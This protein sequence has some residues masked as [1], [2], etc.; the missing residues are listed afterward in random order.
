MAGDLIAHRLGSAY[1]P[2]NSETALRRSL[3]G[4]L[5]GLE[6][7]VCLTADGGLVLLHD[8]LLS[9]GTT[10][11]GW[12]HERTLR[13]IL[14]GS[15]LDSDGE[16]AGEPPLTLEHL[17]E[18]VPLD[19][20]VQVEVKTQSNPELARRTAGAICERYGPS[21]QRDRLEVISFHT[22]ACEVAA[23]AGLRTRLVIWAD[24]APETLADWALRHGVSGV[25]VEYFLLSDELL[26]PLRAAGITV[27]TGTVNDV[28][29][30]E[31]ILRIEPR[32]ITTDRPHELR[33]EALARG[34]LPIDYELPAAA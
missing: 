16:P 8:P 15:L 29:L 17:L 9:L 2:D 4:P 28:D 12:V 6:T 24:Y 21:T 5:K 19:L 27:S 14:G 1:G 34:L 22:D 20:T 30:L 25:K 7:D 33:A 23:A 18:V 26:G 10:L 13:E 11:S 3:S 32:C 31:E